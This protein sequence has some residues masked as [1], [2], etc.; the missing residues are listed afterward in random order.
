MVLDRKIDAA[1]KAQT[2]RLGQS[3]AAGKRKR[4]RKGKSC[5]ASCINN[6][7][8]CLVDLQWVGQGLGMVRNEIQKSP[9]MGKEGSKPPTFKPA[10]QAL[11]PAAHKV[12]K[13]LAILSQP[14][15][16]VSEV[17]GELKA[18]SV[19]W[20][21]GKGKGAEYVASGAFGAFV[22]VPEER[23]AKGL[24]GKFPGG[25][26]IK[27]GDISPKEVELLKKIG[28]S[29]AGPR[30]IAAKYL[31]ESNYPGSP[32]QDSENRKGMI[33]MERIPGKPLEKVSYEITEEQLGDGY[34]KGMAKLHRAGIAHGDAHLGNAI[35]KPDG[36]VKFVDFG[37]AKNSPVSALEEIQNRIWD[38][39]GPIADRIKG[40]LH[41]ITN[42]LDKFSWNKGDMTPDVRDKRAM[43]LIE[44]V[45][46]GV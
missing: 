33:A 36:D 42:E 31:T 34:L 27:Y 13:V 2:A 1:K 7:K 14:D 5:G 12:E 32:N 39:G 30:L 8:F 22:H 44:K 11:P 18:K 28:E 26:G 24:E 4:C 17:N 15:A 38:M 3:G 41:K 6:S 21:S 9:K 25:V 35:M 20:S 23:L 10:S 43:E 46:E 16:K 40:N 19:N 45:Y 37:N 29:G